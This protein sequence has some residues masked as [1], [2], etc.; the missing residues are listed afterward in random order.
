MRAFLFTLLILLALSCK[1][2]NEKTENMDVT[3]LLL[4]KEFS[5]NSTLADSLGADQYGMKKMVIAFL[6]SGPNRSQSQEEA[7]KLQRAHLDNIGR[8]AKEG[9]LVLAGPFLADGELRGLYIF[10]VE[11]LEEARE[12]TAT[13]PAIQQGRLVMELHEWY[14]SAT[15]IL[16]AKLHK[17]VAEKEV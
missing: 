4:Q 13:D 14:G 9:K 12:L 6:K 1:N 3:D 17:L 8:L 10:D 15:T 5:Y 7:Q 16:V 11:T 2:S